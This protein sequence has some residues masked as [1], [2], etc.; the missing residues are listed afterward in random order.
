[1]AKALAFLG[2]GS[3]V[4]KSIV[5]AGVLRWF[6]NK[7]ILCAPY[8][9]QNMSNNSWVTM[10]GGEMGRAQIVQAEA[11]RCEPDTDMNP[12]LL[13]PSTDTG[14]QV[15]LNG[16]VLADK[17][18]RDY[19]E[20]SQSI[21]KEAFKSYDNLAAK[22][23]VIC[24]EG[25]GSCAEMNLKERDFVNFA[26]AL[27]AKAP[28]ILVADIDRGGVFAQVLGSLMIIPE[29]ERQA[30]K[31]I[32]INRFRGDI[33]LFDDGRKYIEE[34]AG[35]PVLGVVP[36]MY[37]LQIDSEDSL[38]LHS[39]LDPKSAP[40]KNK[41]SIAVVFLR[42]I[43][44]HTDINP[45]ARLS[46]VD[47][48]FFS[49][50]KDLSSYDAVIIPGTKNVRRDM[51]FLRE[52]GWDKKIKDFKG[53]LFGIC[54]GYQILGEKIEDP[55]GVEGNIGESDGLN[56]L[57]IKTTLRKEKYL[58]R[59]EGTCA[60]FKSTISGYEIHMGETT[61]NADINLI[62]INKTTTSEN[63]HIEVPY[64]D[65]TV[66]KDDRIMGTYVHGCFDDQ[67]FL[68]GFLNW[69][70]SE[71]AGMFDIED[72]EVIKER[73]LNRLADHFDKHIDME[74]LSQIMDAGL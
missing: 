46:D 20:M 29:E 1:M 43:S 38:P 36:Y 3:D 6:S 52:T 67:S 8:K 28:V 56:L 42:S 40:D 7:G 51:E 64:F 63:L 62:E 71:K 16:Q 35:I 49:K 74:K 57:P 37:D 70:S 44:N 13:K 50:P 25:A 55:F 18:A 4:G 19:F 5:T 15:I 65:G 21:R 66:S 32:I 9:A 26:S 2:T 72:H 60:H 12:V 33:S 47:L 68:R 23:D 31:G 22:F 45:L 30:V 14:S 69:V 61:S 58:A 10:E 39:F 24:L 53:K 34:K 48:H 41:V 17:N 54:G 27:H 59:V 11:A 73:E